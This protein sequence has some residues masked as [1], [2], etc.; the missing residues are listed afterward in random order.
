MATLVVILLGAV[1]YQRIPVDLFPDITF[2]AAA[3]IA[4]YPGAAPE[5][6]EAR[7]TKVIEA[8]MGSV[9]NIKE[10]ISTSSSEQSTVVVMFDWDTDMDMAAIEMREKIDQ[11]ER[12][13]PDDVDEPTVF[14]FDP[15]MLPIMKIAVSGSD[16][17]SQL[18]HLAESV[19][20]HRVER[21]SGVASVDL[22]GGQYQVISVEV[23]PDELSRYNLTLAQISSILRSSNVNL[24]V[25]DIVQDGQK[26]TIRAINELASIE[27]LKQLI[28]GVAPAS[29]VVPTNPLP[30]LGGQ[31]TG[32]THLAV[33]PLL[34]SEVARV[35]EE[36]RGDLGLVR[37]NGKESVVLTVHKQSG[38]NTVAVAAEIQKVLQELEAE[39]PD[40]E[41]TPTMN[42]ARYINMSIDMV[43]RNAIIGGLLA[44]LILFIFL[45][46]LRSTFIVSVAIPVSVIAAFI[47]LYFGDLTLNLMTLSGLALGIGML[48]DN[49][50]VVIENIYR[51][52]EAG[53]SRREAARRGA[54]EVALAITASTLT[55]IAVFLPVVFVGGI[56]G[57]LFKELA[58][59]VTFSLLASLVVALTVIPMMAGTL[60]KEIKG[61]QR[62]KSLGVVREFYAGVVQW[63]LNHRFVTLALSVALLAAS[64]AALPH[65]GLEFMPEGGTDELRVTVTVPQETSYQELEDIVS[66]VEQFLMDFP[67]VQIVES[68]LGSDQQGMLRDS[69]VGSGMRDAELTVIT[70]LNIPNASAKVVSAVNER[71]SNYGRAHVTAESSSTGMQALGGQGVELRILGPSLEKLNSLAAESV[72]LISEIPGFAQVESSLTA[73]LPQLRVEIDRERATALGVSPFT[74]ASVLRTAV[75]GENV[76]KIMHEG[77]NIE[78]WLSVE[79]PE[80]LDSEWLLALPVGAAAGQQVKLGDTAD[81]V[82]Q[83]G[84]KAITRYNN[85]RYVT[86]SA[87]FENKDLGTAQRE[88]TEALEQIDFG[89]DYQYEFTGQVEQMR[90]AFA[91]LSLAVVLAVALVYM[92]MAAQF[93]SLVHPFVIM[94]TMP[95]AVIGVLGAL[96]LT[97]L[98]FSVPSVIGVIVLAGIVVNNGIVMV[99]YIN[100]LR[101]RGLKKLDAI[102]EAGKARMRPIFMTALTTI[103]GLIP[104]AVGSGAGAELQ[105]P[106]AVAVIGGL[107]T[108]TLLTLIV[109]PVMYS[110]FDRRA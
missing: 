47:L 30:G 65:I 54:S 43:K 48:V 63:A 35:S 26:Y 32:Q 100:Q 24:P 13:L 8:A 55:T 91:S 62:T 94:F 89:D 12:F 88:I 64:L 9:S 41:F 40:L 45:R 82:E 36:F 103:L 77:R 15:S 44:V 20:A 42:Q 84:P 27:E 81:M 21:V 11:V 53:A 106:L 110:I 5:E 38:A 80:E 74:V 72:N 46:S 52:L 104:L 67:E 28:I 33:R 22:T 76:T 25:G 71:F 31:G 86:I 69:L 78:V 7:V 92:V 102:V 51:H 96:Y 98:T 60:L 1:S 37:V 19:V 107:A 90:E 70:D 105:R 66:E 109:I 34:L 10:I 39:Y 93:E 87:K 108:A 97:G 57:I 14:K 95:L 58:L 50:I 101:S 75:A 16:E 6:V 85:Q 56:T 83:A 23:N 68:N 3:V 2:P 29:P 79:R 18:R 4:R 73:E 99:D 61:R 17:A 49:S 59:T